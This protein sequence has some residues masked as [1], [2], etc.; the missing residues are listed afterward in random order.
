MFLRLFDC[1]MAAHPDPMSLVKGIPDCDVY[2]PALPRTGIGRTISS[3]ETMAARVHIGCEAVSISAWTPTDVP[4]LHPVHIPRSRMTPSCHR[5][6]AIGD[7]GTSSIH[8]PS[9]YLFR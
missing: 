3:F 1:N 9:F 5:F 4:A 8:P 6:A 2:L 7:Q